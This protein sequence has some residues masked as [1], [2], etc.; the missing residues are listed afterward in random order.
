MILNLFLFYLSI[1]TQ[2]VSHSF[3]EEDNDDEDQFMLLQEKYE[4]IQKQLEEVQI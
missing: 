4:S 2:S 3:Q 1:G